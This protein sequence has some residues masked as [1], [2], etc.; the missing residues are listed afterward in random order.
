MIKE[1]LHLALFALLSYV[2]ITLV[3]VWVHHVCH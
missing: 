2:A 1:I 3:A